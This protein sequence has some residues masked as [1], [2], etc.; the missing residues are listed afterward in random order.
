VRA[1]ASAVAP[2]LVTGVWFLVHRSDARL[3]YGAAV[4]VAIMAGFGAP[5]VLGVASAALVAVAA[6]LEVGL[7]P[8][9]GAGLAIAIVWA[10]AAS[11]NG[12]IRVERE[13]ARSPLGRVAA[14]FATCFGAG[15]APK[16]SGTF[17]A[18]TG[19]PFGFGLALL[20]PWMRG[21]LLLLGTLFAIG[22]AYRYMA[23]GAE[24]LDPKEVV[25]DEWIGVLIPI[26]VVPWEWP[27][28]VAAFVLFRFFDI[29][30]PGPVGY[31][32]RKVKTPAGII[33]DDVVAGALAAVLLAG[34]RIY[35]RS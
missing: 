17:G 14:G 34:V 6:W 5:L 23:E 20:E 13:Q 10:W 7:R 27:W 1:W 35:A 12:A 33:L 21:G 2:A 11:S 4:L 16:A 18:V 19:V 30:K 15:Y 22:V 8:E 32:D 29:A 24:S 3:A 25:I 31:V 9:L 28:G 26:A